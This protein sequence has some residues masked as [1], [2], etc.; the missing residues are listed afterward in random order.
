MAKYC[1]KCGKALPEGVEICPDCNALGQ[2]EADAALFTML[3]SAEIWRESEEDEKKKR[4]RARKRHQN[5]KR[6]S[7][8]ALA[9]ALALVIAFLVLWFLP[10]S[11]VQRAI[12]KGEY[13]T[14]LSL[15]SE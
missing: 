1:V 12:D 7:L 15:W 8:I 11:Q 5:K 9:V 10:V 6:N 3:S 4:E 13:E 2:S 14:A